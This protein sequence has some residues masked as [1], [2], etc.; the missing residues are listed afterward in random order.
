MSLDIRRATPEEADILTGIACA[1]KRHWGYPE[2]WIRE[3][4]PLLTITPE[5]IARLETWCA[6]TGGG[7][8]AFC[9]VNWQ[10]ERASLE[11][12]WVLPFQ[13]GQGVGRALFEHAVELA[14]A[15]GCDRLEIESDP[16]AAGLY[17]KIGAEQAGQRASEV[18]GQPRMLP[19]F[20][21][22]L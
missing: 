22:R 7:V 11:Y 9:A 14:R 13:M 16:Y 12:L 3:W 21:R 10:G 1:A 18:E 2:N 6:E 8:V 4:A 19:V 20:I 17:E 15:R 5:T